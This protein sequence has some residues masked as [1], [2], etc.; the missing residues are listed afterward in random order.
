MLGVLSGVIRA[1]AARALVFAAAGAAAAWGVAAA[2]VLASVDD[3]L[4]APAALVAVLAAV[5]VAAR[6]AAA[7]ARGPTATERREVALGLATVA[8]AGG[9]ATL[10]YAAD[11]AW[12]LAALGVSVA[13]A[14]AL[15]VNF[16]RP[17]TEGEGASAPETPRE[18]A[19]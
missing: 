8:F 6:A 13:V 9:V 1:R 14:A 16:A 19:G 15:A 18:S 7:G 4:A 10:P 2:R 5:I 17:A 12:G 11:D 3:V